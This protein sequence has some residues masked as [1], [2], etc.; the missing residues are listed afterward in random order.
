VTDCDRFLDALASDGPDAEARAHALGCDRCRPLLPDGE[1]PAGEDSAA[2][3][4][5]QGRALDVLRRTP[6]RRWTRDAAVLALLQSAVACAVTVLLGLQNWSSPGSHHAAL[7]LVGITLLGVVA[8]GAFL[9]LAPGR[10]RPRIL[11]WTIPVIPVLLVLAGN[12]VHTAQTMRA[13]LPCAV[14]VVL[15]AAVPLGVGMALLRGMALDGAR[16]AALALSAAGT[17]LFA[18]HWHCTDGSAGHLMGFHAL[19][20]VALALLAIPL[21][22]AL[23]T[24]D[25]VP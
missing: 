17:G 4:A 9:A 23:P 16:T 10:R 18:L 6:A 3:E 15:T 2:L 19:P 24:R 8:P 14:T 20:W 11:L 5:L 1:A 22:R 13:S 7:A 12:G 25:H 21:R